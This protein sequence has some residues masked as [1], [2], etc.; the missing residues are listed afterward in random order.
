[1]NKHWREG[2]PF[3]LGVSSPQNNKIYIK[4][5]TLLRTAFQTLSS[6]VEPPQSKFP[7]FEKGKKII[8]G[9]LF[10]D[11]SEFVGEETVLIGKMR[12]ILHSSVVVSKQY[13][14]RSSQFE[15]QAL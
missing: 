15:N 3:I 5:K 11:K 1:M 4:E 6:G 14:A 10:L 13:P 7:S 2:T 12:G 9:N 8:Y